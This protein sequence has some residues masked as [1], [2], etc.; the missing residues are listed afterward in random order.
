MLLEV[1][2]EVAGSGRNA[3]TLEYSLPAAGNV[4]VAVY[5][6]TGRRVSTLVNEYQAAGDHRTTWN[7]ASV[8]QGM[9]FVRLRA[10]SASITKSV[11][12]LE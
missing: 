11:L 3:A 10:G 8:A 7:H 9:Y 6:V 1:A 2:S 4:I 12:I 5:D